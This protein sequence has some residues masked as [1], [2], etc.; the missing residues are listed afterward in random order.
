MES[1]LPSWPEQMAKL[2]INSNSCTAAF[3]QVAGI[4]ALESDQTPVTKMV[5]TFRERRDHVVKLSTRLKVSPVRFLWE[6]SMFFPEL[7]I[8]D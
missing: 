3:T 5:E 4:A 2:M 7:A 8:W 1:C 6:L